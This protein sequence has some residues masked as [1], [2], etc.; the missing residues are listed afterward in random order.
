MARY[1]EAIEMLY[2]DNYFYMENPR[3]LLELPKYMPQLRLHSF[4]YL[5]L[6]S[7]VYSDATPHD[8][9]GRWKEVID[10]LEKLDSSSAGNYYSVRMNPVSEKGLCE[11][12][13]FLNT[14]NHLH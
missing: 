11:R 14:G 9:L 8:R 7:A 2:Q 12:Y 13:Q 1:S 6:Q 5:C 4:R 10:A 3:T